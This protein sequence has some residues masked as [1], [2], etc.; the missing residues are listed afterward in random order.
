M[1]GFS[2]VTFLLSLLI[3]ISSK[4]HAEIETDN[5]L[6]PFLIIATTPS[7]KQLLD[8]AIYAEF[9]TSLAK[10]Q[11]DALVKT[12]VEKQSFEHNVAVHLAYIAILMALNEFDQVDH[13]LDKLHLLAVK[14]RKDWVLAKVFEQHAVLWLRRGNFKKSL[15]EINK[16]IKM[17]HSTTFYNTE[18]SAT[19]LRAILYGKMGRFNQA[20]EDNLSALKYFENKKNNRKIANLYSNVVT[21]YLYRLDHKNALYYSDKAINS[22]NALARKSYRQM[23]VN[24]IN[25]AIALGHLNRI[26]EELVAMEKARELSKKINDTELLSSIYANLSDYYLRTKDFQ[27]AVGRA[28]ECL[29]LTRKINNID[30]ETICL[31]NLGLAQVNLG[32]AESGLASLHQAHEIIEKE[33]LDSS[34]VGVYQMLSQAY[35]TLGDF[36]R[37]LFWY[38][39]YHQFLTQQSKKDKTD[40]QESIEKRYK[41]SVKSKQLAHTTFKDEMVENVLSL[42]TLVKIQWWVIVGIL[43]VLSML[44]IL[45]LLNVRRKNK[46]LKQEK[47]EKE[48][49]TN[50]PT[51]DIDQDPA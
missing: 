25:R 9:D 44:L 49:K 4:T 48:Y 24:Y 11:L 2:W 12:G 34:L 30:I 41:E 35:E 33:H 22:M 29:E 20:I 28:E 42:E 19:G 8:L 27:L 43:S 17:S 47:A 51:T 45:Y 14:K 38:K 37:S 3:F 5:G 1:K 13:Y 40:Y 16:A 31:M 6:E 7:G 10:E 18:A 39:N 32:K 21:I 50:F 46:I 15:M 36:D 23:A 26:E